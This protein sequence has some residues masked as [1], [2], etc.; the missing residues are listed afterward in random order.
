MLQDTNNLKTSATQAE[1]GL[2]MLATAIRDHGIQQS[3]W[4]PEGYENYVII[5]E[6][7]YD[8]K[9]E[10]QL[11]AALQSVT[12]DGQVIH[13]SSLSR[14]LVNRLSLSEYHVCLK[15]VED[16]NKLS[17]LLNSTAGNS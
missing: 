2:K 14:A 16:Y 17:A 4:A 10:Q 8:P 13:H 11:N 9:V 6:K 3:R 1:E 12:A 7:N 15:G 5:V